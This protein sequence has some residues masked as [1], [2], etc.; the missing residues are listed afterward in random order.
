V[1]PVSVEIHV[2]PRVNHLL[3]QG[4]N[5]IPDHPAQP[6]SAAGKPVS[7]GRVL[8]R[9]VLRGQI[10]VAG[11]PRE[12]AGPDAEPEQLLVR[13]GSGPADVG[14]LGHEDVGEHFRTTGSSTTA[15]KPVQ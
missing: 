12:Q 1:P 2:R 8:P 10:T 9:R 3:P 5:P 6:D 11:G 13:A 7:A 4:Y 14:A 15:A